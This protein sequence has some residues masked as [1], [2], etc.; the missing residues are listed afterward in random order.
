ME[1]KPDFVYA[2]ANLA[3]V[4]ANLGDIDAAAEALEKAV[5]ADTGVFFDNAR[6]QET[7]FNLGAAAMKQKRYD[8]A[9]E[10]FRKVIEAVPTNIDAKRNLGLS[11]HMQGRSAEGIRELEE[12]IRKY[13]NSAEAYN[14]L[15]LI[16]ADRGQRQEA[17]ANFQKALSINPNF[18]QA[19]ANLR[20]LNE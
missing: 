18:V 1:R 11:L 10:S 5:R 2:L 14:T 16:Y 20:K 3:S 9:A 17:A 12:T 7:Y 8:R 4:S 19:Q 6:I 13:P 15:G